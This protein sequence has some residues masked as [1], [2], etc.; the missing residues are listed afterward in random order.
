M[1]RRGRGPVLLGFW[2][3]TVRGWIS[4][5]M[6]RRRAEELSSMEGQGKWSPREKRTNQSKCSRRSCAWLLLLRFFGLTRVLFARAR[7]R[8]NWAAVKRNATIHTPSRRVH[9]HKEERL[10]QAFIFLPGTVAYFQMTLGSQSFFFLFFSFFC[11]YEQRNGFAI[12]R[13][14]W[15]QRT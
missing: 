13:K 8:L 12:L 14:P 3:A 5:R 15:T 10:G 7:A 9:L 11:Y 2:S 4:P 1:D 6:P